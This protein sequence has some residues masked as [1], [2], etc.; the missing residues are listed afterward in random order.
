M[1]LALRMLPV[2]DGSDFMGSLRNPAAFNNVFGMRP[3]FGRVPHGPDHDVFF[4]QFGTEGPMARSVA[5]LAMLLSVQAGFDRRAPLSNPQDPAMFAGS[6]DTETQGLRI[7]WLGD[8]G[9]YLA[10]EPGVLDVCERALDRF[11]ALG[12]TVD[13]VQPAFAPERL[14][15]TWLTMRAFSVASRL[16][17]LHADPARRAQMKPAAIWE[18]ENGLALTADAVARASAD[19]SAWYQALDALFTRFDFLVLPSAQVFP[20]DASWDWPKSIAGRAMDTYHRW[21][22][23]VI[24]PTLAGLPALSVPAGFSDDGL[25]MGMQIIGPA[26]ADL[27]VLKIGHAYE[28]GCDA[29]K[30]RSPLLDSLRHD[31]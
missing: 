16:S 20:F 15:D 27:A 17:V 23:V 19:R 31:R 24:G 30:R 4:A 26:H 3:S 8:F 22:E 18:V 12:C 25:P 13:A 7:G 5:D 11:R 28:Q 2:A 6:L 29:V 1:A 21:M 10:M 9:G 14:W